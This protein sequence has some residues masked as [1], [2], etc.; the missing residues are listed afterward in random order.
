M[1]FTSWKEEELFSMWKG[2]E[3][4]EPM[5]TWLKSG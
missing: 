4:D 5:M 3:K 1:V 2:K